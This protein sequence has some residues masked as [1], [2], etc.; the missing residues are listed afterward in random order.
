MTAAA[1]PSTPDADDTPTPQP[2]RS[3]AIIGGGFMGAG[4][5]Q[6]AAPA[7]AHAFVEQLGERAIETQ[8]SSA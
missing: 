2:I 4:I 8:D 6:S 5:A 1:R 7:G 3:P